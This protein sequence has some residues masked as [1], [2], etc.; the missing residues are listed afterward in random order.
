MHLL[1]NQPEDV[2]FGYFMAM[3]ND[4]FER[5]LALADEGYESGS[6]T[7][8]LPT[9]LRC[10]SRIHHVSSNENFS[11]NPSTPCTTATSQSYHKSVC[12]HSSFSSSDAEDNSTSLPLNS[13]GFAKSPTKFT[14]TICDDS[15]EK[16]DFQSVTL[17]NNHGIIDPV[18]DRHLCI[19]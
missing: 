17:G 18:P 5:E 6:E 1:H 2:L 11:F 13:M 8:D 12:C 15:E 14:Y 10:T 7:S 16:E 19:H 4:A 3:L 9:P